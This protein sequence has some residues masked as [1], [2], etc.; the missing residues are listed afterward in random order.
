MGI[1]S[2]LVSLRLDL[3]CLFLPPF[4]QSREGSS[5][6]RLYSQIL[7][8]AEDKENACHSEERPCNTAAV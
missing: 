6:S 2:G 7:G 8:G 3:Q 1:V 5:S 4:Q